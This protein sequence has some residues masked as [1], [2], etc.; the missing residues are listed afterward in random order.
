M[1]LVVN[2]EKEQ[3]KEEVNLIDFLN[4]KGLELDRLVIEYNKQ[5]IPQ[6]EWKNTTLKDQDTL[7]V[8]RFVGG[9]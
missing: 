4:S 9:G 8:L 5:V 3:L 7:E 2:G 1:E 6:E